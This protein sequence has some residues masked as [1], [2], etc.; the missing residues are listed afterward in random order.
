MPY[1]MTS[2]VLSESV[3]AK[4][5]DTAFER[6]LRNGD[7]AKL[8]G[9]KPQQVSHC[10]T[11]QGGVSKEKL[12]KICQ[13]LDIQPEFVMPDIPATR[14]RSK[15]DMR[16]IRRGLS[17]REAGSKESSDTAESISREEFKSTVAL[18]SKILSICQ[19]PEFKNWDQVV[20]DCEIAANRALLKISS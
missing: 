16:L 13:A 2:R 11:R 20:R 1:R 8:A 15:E 6:N 7:I 19:N 10:Y 12:T 17:G 9:V 18:A 5:K 14:R 3:V 4:I